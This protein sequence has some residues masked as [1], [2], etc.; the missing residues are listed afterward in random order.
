MGCAR[1]LRFHSEMDRK[2]KT[3]VGRDRIFFFPRLRATIF[4]CVDPLTNLVSARSVGGLFRLPGDGQER[5][6][7]EFGAAK[8]S[9][10]K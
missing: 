3:S 5:E 1:V 4:Q 6:P 9:A 7:S 2:E 10:K 8:N